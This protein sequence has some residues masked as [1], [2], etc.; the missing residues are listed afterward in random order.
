MASQSVQHFAS[1]IQYLGRIHVGRANAPIRVDK[2][3]YKFKKV[4]S[5]THDCLLLWMFGWVGRC[6]C[7]S[8]PRFIL[9]ALGSCYAVHKNA[10]SIELKCT[11]K[12]ITCKLN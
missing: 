10:L 4:T 9:F 1:H 3:I 6:L 2:S 7:A 5:I 12:G 8:D 11:S